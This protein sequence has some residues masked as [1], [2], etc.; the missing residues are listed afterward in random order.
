MSA[1][2]AF[3]TFTAIVYVSGT[4][5]HSVELVF[6]ANAHMEVVNCVL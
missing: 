5:S 1:R 4:F 2:F 6:F 3:W